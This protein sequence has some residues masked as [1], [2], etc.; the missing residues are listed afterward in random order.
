MRIPVAAFVFLVVP[1]AA[2]GGHAPAAPGAPALQA[3]LIGTVGADSGAAAFSS[4]RSVLLSPTGA[5]ALVDDRERAI[6]IF[7]SVGA[8]PRSLGRTGAGP[9]EFAQPYSLAWMGDTLALLDW[10][11]SRIGLFD[12]QG[13]W[14][15]NW[16]AQPISGGQSVRLYRTGRRDFWR[17]GYAVK[18]GKPQSLFIHYTTTGPADTLEYVYPPLPPALAITCKSARAINFFSA[19]FAPTLLEIPTPE[20]ARAVATTDRYRIVMLG[21]KGDTLR[22]IALNEPADPIADSEWTAGLAEWSEFQQKNPG[23]KCDRDGFERPAA[24][25]PL[26]A[27]FY[28][29]KGLLWVE[30][31]TPAGSRYDRYDPSGH[32]LPSITGLPPTG[33]ID[34]SIAGDR[35]AIVL[36]GEATFPRV[37]IYR[38]VTAPVGR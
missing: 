22:T 13:K 15:G 20:G 10:G 33:G 2:C 34:P 29:D 21:A 19:P 9:G 5:L 38:F 3:E 26:L 25:P 37:G 31:R 28:D 24:K 16:P 35:I 30:V 4:I 32:P 6:W 23:A 7:D 1:L 11:N 14:A 18:E 8:V 36:G 27:L 17:Y 12:A